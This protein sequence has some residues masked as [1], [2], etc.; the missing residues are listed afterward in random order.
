[1]SYKIFNAYK[2]SLDNLEEAM[3]FLDTS[4][5]EKTLLFYDALMQSLEEDTIKEKYKI[6]AENP[7]AYNNMKRFYSH[8][9]IREIFKA[10]E[11]SCYYLNTGFNVFIYNKNAYFILYGKV[12]DDF[13]FTDEELPDYWPSYLVGFHYQT[14]TDPPKSIP[15]EEYDSRAAEW[16]KVLGDYGLNQ[17]HQRRLLR[18]SIFDIAD[19]NTHHE[20]SLMYDQRYPVEVVNEKKT[21]ATRNGLVRGEI[22]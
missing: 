8:I 7:E 16:N 13:D 10:T 12:S 18:H 15:R 14:A 17:Y 1:M 22:T 20:L 5:R 3:E 6:K 9:F 4:I 11:E 2:C 21:R 19:E